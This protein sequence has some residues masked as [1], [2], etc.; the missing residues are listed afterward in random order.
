MSQLSI[1]FFIEHKRY[2]QQEGYARTTIELYNKLA[3]ENVPTLWKTYIQEDFPDNFNLNIKNISNLKT[4]MVGYK[5]QGQSSF[6]KFIDFLQKKINNPLTPPNQTPMKDKI[7]F[8]L[9]QILYGPPGTGKTYLTKKLAV[10]IIDGID[11]AEEDRKKIL[12]RYNVLSDLGQVEFVTFH[13]SMGY[14]DFVEGIKP[15][16]AEDSEG[17]SLLYDIENGIFKSISTRAKGVSGNKNKDPK[18]DFLKPSYFK[19]SLGGINRKD[20]HKWCIDNNLIAL[21]WGDNEDYTKYNSI[22]EWTEF[23][24]KFTSEFGYLVEGSKYV[25]NAVY[26]FQKMKEGDIVLISIG[27]QIID[28]IGVIEGDYKYDKDNTFGFHH[29]RKVKWLSTNMNASPDLFVGKNISQQSIYEFNKQDIKIDFFNSLF[30]T[31]ASSPRKENYVLIIDEINRGNVSAI[32]GELITLLEED[33]RKGSSKMETIQVTLPYSKEKFSVPDNLYIIGTMNTAD[34]S[35]EALDTALRR[36][37]SFTELLPRSEILTPYKHIYK[38]LWDYEEYSWD[39]EEWGHVEA[40]LK[41]LYGLDKNWEDN[42]RDL[43]DKFLKNERNSEDSNELK[44]IDTP[45]LDLSKILHTINN[46]IVILL[47]KDHTIGHSYFMN[48]NSLRDLVEVFKNK[49]IPLLEEYFF[50]DFGKIG[51]V[52]GGGFIA[53]LDDKDKIEFANNFDYDDSNQFREKS[54][55]EFTNPEDWNLETFLSIYTMTD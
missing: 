55:Y 25:I 17:D 1:K 18:I 2:L 46:R 50:G 10:Q 42:K 40:D 3:V 14:E 45:K 51:L 30:S 4:L 23:K 49:V 48:A 15:V 32:F 36:R 21:G 37:F 34:R 20:I 12:E 38:L 47:D 53:K 19:M 11:Y 7:V 24:E 8:P 27:N 33:K 28:A 22:N 44:V 16:F 6:R 29:T 41:E 54:I 35:V 43:W 13:Q 26:R 9:N 39:S 52:L 31:S 5:F